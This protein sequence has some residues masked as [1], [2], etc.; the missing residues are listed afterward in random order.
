MPMVLDVGS[1]HAQS[2]QVCPLFVSGSLCLFWSLLGQCVLISFGR[3]VYIDDDLVCGLPLLLMSISDSVFV[4][5]G[6]PSFGSSMFLSLCGLCD[7]LLTFWCFQSWKT[8]LCLVGLSGCFV[9]I[10]SYTVIAIVDLW[11]FL[12]L[13]LVL[14]SFAF[15]GSLWDRVC[16]RAVGVGGGR[17]GCCH[18]NEQFLDTCS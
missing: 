11:F 12:M 3:P 6:V 7:L 10:V 18:R 15:R 16:W 8:C 1:V 13:L 9:L 5:F 17:H 14:R 4:G 2:D